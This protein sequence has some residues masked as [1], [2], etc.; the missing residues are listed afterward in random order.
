MEV[1]AGGFAAAADNGVVV[2]F[3]LDAWTTRGA[4]L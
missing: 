4:S 3:F 1:A 2:K